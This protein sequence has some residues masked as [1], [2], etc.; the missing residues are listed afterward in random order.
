M[1]DAGTTPGSAGRAKRGR[2]RRD[3]AWVCR[4]GT[5]LGR[6]VRISIFTRIATWMLVASMSRVAC[7]ATATAAATQAAA[8]AADRVGQVARRFGPDP[9][10][11]GYDGL[12]A[13]SFLAAVPPEQLTTLFRQMYGQAGR[14][15]GV[16]PEGAVSAA[17]GKFR[18]TF[19]KGMTAVATVSVESGE[20]HRID[21]LWLGPFEA[22]VNDFPGLI[23]QLGK[24][25]GTASLYAAGLG[26]KGDLTPLAAYN[27]DRPLGI[28]SAFKLY[29]LAEL[30]REVNDGHRHWEDV[31]RLEAR[32]RSLPSGTLQNWPAGSPL[33]LQTLATL[34]ISVSDN[35]AAD[36]L[37]GTLGRENIEAVLGPA[38]HAE[39]LL[40]E[41]FLTTGE[42]FRIKADPALSDRFAHADTAG[43]R[44]LLAG[45]VAA[46]DIGSVG[47]YAEPRH[48]A[49]IE[50]LATTA[51]LGR[52]MQYLRDQ[53]EAG[54]PAA[55]A[56]AVLAVNPGLRFD[57]QAWPYVGF[58]G[59]SEPGV[60]NLTF[61]LRS[62]SGRWFVL[63]TTWND[64]AAALD[65]TRL[66]GLTQAAVSLL[67]K[68]P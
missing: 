31:V 9:A 43:R 39:P 33:T 10:G 30:A 4:S 5:D 50:W 57:S 25:P 56:R 41:P 66:L 3:T 23:D 46:V 16:A 60:L 58:K 11:G 8:T 59:G 48:V 54:R 26:D 1:R 14:C 28:G 17:G 19:E 47:P 6:V 34:M 18:L 40:D 55:P 42:L 51:D 62:R 44:A 36:E 32:R 45:P 52:A 64:P 65:E 24:L 49:D 7:A 12:F 35:T 53:T 63:S 21:G 67:S 2:L 13:P 22:N 61:L 37:A 20:P 27:A 29:V 38:G 15:T 68:A